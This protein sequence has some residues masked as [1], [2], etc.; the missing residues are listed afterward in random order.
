MYT[1]APEAL[2][3]LE[4]SLEVLFWYG[5]ETSCCFQLIVFCRRYTLTNEPSVDCWE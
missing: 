3:L 4:A 2:L 1:L 5:C